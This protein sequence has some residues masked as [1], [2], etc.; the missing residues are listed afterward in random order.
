MREFFTKLSEVKWISDFI[1]DFKQNFIDGD[2]WEWLFEGLLNTLI[3]TFF[4]TL[5]GIAIGIVIAVIRSTY[6]KNAETLKKRGGIGYGIL[7]FANG[8]CNVYL[9]VFRGTPVV[10]QLM[11]WYFVILAFST[12]GIMVAVVAF[13]INSGAYVAEIF[14]GGIMSI[15]NGQFEAGRSLG[16]NYIS[17]M[18]YIVAPQMIKAVLP[19]LCNEFIVLLKETSIAGYVG[20][21]DLTKAGDLIRGR[22]FAAFMPLIAVAIIYFAIV[23]IFTRL[24]NVLERR[25]RRSD[26]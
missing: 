20:I 10:V 14:R 24:V 15:D 26:H 6:D 23:M 1:E 21:M 9:A 4:A 12:N 5:I 25:L 3:I 18:I 19:T 22:T 8:V 11:I 7:K 2:R 17:T 13:G 16:F